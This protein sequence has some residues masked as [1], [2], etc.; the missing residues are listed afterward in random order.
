MIKTLRIT[1][2]IAAVL[3]AGLFVFPAIFGLRSNEDIKNF[4]SLPSVVENIRKA[5]GDRD[6]GGE[7]QISPLV[8]QAQAFGLYLNPPKPVK[9]LTRTRKPDKGDIVPKPPPRRL[10]PKFKVI[11]TSYYA[12]HPELSLVL[13]DEPGKGRHWVRESTV[14]SHLTIEQIKDGLV[15]VRGAKGT[16]ELAPEPR[17]LQRSLVAGSFPVSLE[18]GGQAR[19]EFTSALGPSEAEAVT[20]AGDGI[21]RSELEQMSPEEQAAYAQKIFAELAAMGTG[22]RP[23]ESDQTGSEPNAGVEKPVSDFEDMRIS[24]KEAKKL[25]HLGQ[26]LKGGPGGVEQDPNRPKSRKTEKAARESWKRRKPKTLSRPK[27]TAS[28]PR[29][30]RTKKKPTSN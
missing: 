3:A 13:I 2:I 5:K 12:S 1:S 30:K 24:G 9:Q 29:G 19:P 14:V 6:K 16:F 8:K 7:G 4:L 27:G 21:T 20:D 18:T 17:P 26:E 22:E 23:I 15:V 11:A 10:T 25:G 28:R